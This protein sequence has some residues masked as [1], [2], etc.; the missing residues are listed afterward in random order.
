MYDP[1]TQKA[2]DYLHST[3][4]N[5]DIARYNGMRFIVTGEEGLDERWKDTP[6]LTIQRIYVVSTNKPVVPILKSPRAST[7]H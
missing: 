1:S 2:I 6:V 5:L 3:S 4:T 7:M